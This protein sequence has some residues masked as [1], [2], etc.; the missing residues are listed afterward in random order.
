MFHLGIL[1]IEEIQIDFNLAK[2]SLSL[3]VVFKDCKEVIN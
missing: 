3:A 1:Y 2:I